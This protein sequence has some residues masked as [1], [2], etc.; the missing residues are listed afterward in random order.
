MAWNDLSKESRVKGFEIC[1]REF[2]AHVR[3]I[4]NGIEGAI[5]V[6]DELPHPALR[7]DAGSPQLSD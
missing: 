1:R 6:P 4:W 2:K 7:G 5:D 3:T